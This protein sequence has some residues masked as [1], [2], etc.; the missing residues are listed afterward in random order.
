MSVPKASDQ[1]YGTE[2]YRA[3]LP[4]QWSLTN[5]RDHALFAEGLCR[6]WSE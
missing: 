2:Y 6:F 4:P 3:L 5:I 1:R